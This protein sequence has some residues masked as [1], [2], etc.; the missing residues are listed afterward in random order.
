[1]VISDNIELRSMADGSMYTSKR[2]YYRS[3]KEK[4]C[5]IVEGRTDDLI[6]EG[7]NRPRETKSDV[8]QDVKRVWD[9]LV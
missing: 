2:G 1:M 8:G 6:P 9:S 4:G 5:E 3:L 7:P